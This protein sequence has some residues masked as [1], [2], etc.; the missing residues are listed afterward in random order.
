MT[1]APV[2]DHISYSSISLFQA[3]PLRFYFRYILGLPEDVVSASLVFGSALHRSVQYH[4][5]QLLAGNGPPDLDT[6]LGVYQDSWRDRF[7][8]NNIK[9]NKG[10]N[11]DTLGLLADRM[12]RVFQKSDFASPKGVILG[13]E[14]EFR[15]EI[16]PGCPDLL[17]RIDLVVDTGD[18]LLVSD[19]K[20]SRSTWTADH[21]GESS[22]QLLLYSELVKELA[23]GR[24]IRLEFAV[25]TKAKLPEMIRNP[26]PFNSAQVERTKK[27]VANV[28][29]AIQTGNFY[30]Y[31][32]KDVMWRN[33]RTSQACQP[34]GLRCA[35]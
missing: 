20:T 15:A 25:L 3:C 1:N 14:E 29:R 23:E 6:L 10:E 4:F 7:W 30:P 11:I 24:K 32:V 18:E 35:T 16:V 12:L 5:E 13:I 8:Q 22:S 34:C 9:F 17:A 26:V 33:L 2:F 19:F 27:V 28:W 31:V 21:I